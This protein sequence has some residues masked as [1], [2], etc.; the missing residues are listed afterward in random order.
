MPQTFDSLYHHNKFKHLPS[1][2]SL[3]GKILLKVYF[4]SLHSI[5]KKKTTTGENVIT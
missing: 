3:K 2:E 1:P 5:L 4:F